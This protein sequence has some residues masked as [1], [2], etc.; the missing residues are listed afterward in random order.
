MA[1]VLIQNCLLSFDETQLEGKGYFLELW[2]IKNPVEGLEEQASTCSDM[3]CQ[4]KSDQ[5]KTKPWSS[6]EWLSQSQVLNIP[7]IKENTQR[8]NN[9]ARVNQQMQ[10]VRKDWG[11]N[12]TKNLGADAI[13]KS[14]P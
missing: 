4:D 10:W 11:P 14:Q 3:D 9:V 12:D 7:I 2:E 8:C 1:S 5:K 6:S 13:A